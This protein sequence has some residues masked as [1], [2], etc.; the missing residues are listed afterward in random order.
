MYGMFDLIYECMCIAKATECD[1]RAVGADEITTFKGGGTACVFYPK[2]EESF[3]N[4]YRVLAKEIE[5]P[6]ILGGGSDTVIADGLCRVPIISTAGLNSIKI[7]DGKAYAGAGARL[8]D[9][10]RAF[11]K[12]NLG[13]FEFLC[14]VPLTV[15]GAVRMNASAFDNETASYI[16]EIRVLTPN[17]AKS[18]ENA[19]FSIETVNA[20]KLDFGYR[21]GFD[22][23][24][25]SAVLKADKIDAEESKALAKKYLASRAKKQPKYPSCGSVFK[26]GADYS[27][28]KLIDDCGLKGVKLGGAQISEMH[29]NFIVNRGGASAT[30][31]MSLVRLAEYCVYAKFG[32]RLQREFI[33]LK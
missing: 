3:I 26:N 19:D 25:L 20:K 15:G 33:Y 27:S 23:I 14:G 21:D 24:V 1:F 2:D 30:D 29:G 18:A 32:V 31:F 16:E 22:G 9:V 4:V 8:G 17:G 5:K 7:K 12:K 13:G 11:R 28:G 6:F 10:T